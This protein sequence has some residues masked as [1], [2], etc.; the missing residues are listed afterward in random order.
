[1]KNIHYILATLHTPAPKLKHTETH[2]PRGVQ[3]TLR[4]TL[5]D[6]LGN[7]FWH[8]LDDVQTLSTRMTRREMADIRV[9]GNFT[10]GVSFRHWVSIEETFFYYKLI[11]T[12]IDLLSLD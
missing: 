1:M 8:Q 11:N 6:N 7:E 4:V 9:G 5:H 12:L 10:I 3:L 2:V